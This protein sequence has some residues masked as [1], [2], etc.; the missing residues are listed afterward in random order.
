MSIWLRLCLRLAATVPMVVLVVVLAFRLAP[1]DARAVQAEGEQGSAGLDSAS[2]QRFAEDHLL[3]ASLARQYFHALGP[4]DLSP[5]GHEW[6]GGDGSR[7]WHGLLVF[8]FGSELARPQVRISGEL[9]TRAATTIPLAVSAF[10]LSL[11]LAA[12]AGV[13]LAARRG[14]RVARLAGFLLLLVD[15][16]PGF[17]LALLLV[18]AFGPEGAGWFPA[19]G[20]SSRGGELPSVVD[21]VWHMVLPVLAL[22]L[23]AVAHVARQLASSLA[24]M[25]REE[26]LRAARANGLTRSQAM[27]RHALRHALPPIVG[28]FGGALPALLSGS[29]VVETIFGLQGLG[30]YAAEAVYARDHAVVLAACTLAAVLAVLGSALADALLA[31]L[32]P[33]I[34]A[35]GEV[36]HG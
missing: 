19:T 14:S 25:E 36:Q 27:W 12:P 22:S 26:W 20:L 8:E 34:G 33:R 4:F 10:A 29:V 32:D 3:D 2:A 30:S 6:F 31:R 35:A 13:W 9:A 11:L 18:R 21:R 1:G 17:A 24:A 23:G 15:A 28:L 5:R 7:P 16:L